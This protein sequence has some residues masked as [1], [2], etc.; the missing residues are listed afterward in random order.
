M[1]CFA[2]KDDKCTVLS[3]GICKGTSCGFYKTMEEH[4]QSI[5]K[6]DER[7]RSLPDYQQKDIADRYYGGVRKW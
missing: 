7:L 1:N 2:M 3:G 5:Q 6:A 4:H